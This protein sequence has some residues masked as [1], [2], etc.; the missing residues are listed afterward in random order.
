VKRSII[1]FFLLVLAVTVISFTDRAYA[2]G[3]KIA[4]MWVGESFPARNNLRGLLPRLKKLAPDAN[5]TVKMNL[6]DFKVAEQLFREFEG[7]M[8]GIVFLRTSGAQFLATAAPKIPCFVGATNNPEFLGVVKNLNSPEGKVTGVTY[9]LPYE[10][11]FT[12]I[13]ELFPAV[14]NVCLLM[15]KDHP[16]IP[17]ERNGTSQQCEKLGIS[18]REIIA[19]TQDELVQAV[20]GMAGQVG[21]FII[22]NHSLVEKST[23]ELLKVTQ[24]AKVPIYSYS[25][26]PVEMGALAGLAAREE[27][28]GSLLAESIV[29]VVVMGKPVASVPVK[30]DPD[31]QLMLNEAGM[32]FFGLRLPP[33]V[34]RKARIVKKR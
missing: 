14:K 9:Y 26:A 2:D 15:E 16:S 17:I 7:T 32:E 21:L 33:P 27:L 11:R 18:Y 4:I 6:E 13:R 20:K 22:A 31:P 25:D 19:G 23:P 12:G 24:P 29:D 8:D 3:K 28:L 34:L 10:K 30:T 5:I 1:C